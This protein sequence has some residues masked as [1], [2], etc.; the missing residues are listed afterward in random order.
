M[1][2]VLVPALVVL[3]L[4]AALLSVAGVLF[5]RS[6]AARLHY[7]STL[8]MTAAPLIGLAALIEVG[9]FTASGWAALATLL[10]L[11]GQSPLSGHTLGRLIRLHDTR[12]HR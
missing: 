12:S 5:A 4:A 8:T 9:L 6:A 7:L 10:V 1:S 3:G 2:A 11:V